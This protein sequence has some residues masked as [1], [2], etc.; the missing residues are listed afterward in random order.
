MKKILTVLLAVSITTAVL[1]GC[2]GSGWNYPKEPTS[3]TEFVLTLS[4]S[5]DPHVA[6]S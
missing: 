5:Y 4:D 1:A 6:I 3:A 2:G